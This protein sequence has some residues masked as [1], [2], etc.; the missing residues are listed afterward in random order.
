[1]AVTLWRIRFGEL[2]AG[3]K[4]KPQKQNQKLDEM[5]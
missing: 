3:K 4:A 1:M 5:S 2:E